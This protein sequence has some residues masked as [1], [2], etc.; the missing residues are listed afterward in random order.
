[1]NASVGLS[2]ALEQVRA[3]FAAEWEQPSR[4]SFQQC[5]SEVTAAEQ[6]QLL[7]ALV[8]VDWQERSKRGEQPH[9]EEYVEQFPEHRDALLASHHP[10]DDHSVLSTI[11][12]KS[13]KRS[14]AGSTTISKQ[15][16]R[17][18]LQKILGRGGFGIVWKALDPA[19]NRSVAIKI[20]RSDRAD[21]AQQVALLEEARKIAQLNHQGILKIHD[22][23]L[24]GDA[25]CI[26]S[27]WIGGGTLAEHREDFRNNPAAAA[28]LIA[29]AAD[30]LHYAHVCGIVHRDIKPQ[31]IL[32]DEHGRSRIADFGLAVTET[33]QLSEARGV[34]GTLAY[35][36]PEILKGD[37]QFAD[38]RSDVY[39]LGAV[40]YEML[41]GRRPFVAHNSDQWIEQALEREPRPPRSIDDRIPPELERICL[42][43]L[44]KKVTDRYTTAHDLAHDLR[45]AIHGK[46]DRQRQVAV[47]SVL[48]IAATLLIGFLL[49]KYVL[50][51]PAPQPGPVD[52][53]KAGSPSI[54]TG[55]E[56]PV[57]R[58]PLAAEFDEFP[59]PD[60]K[61]QIGL[62]KLPPTLFWPK[63]RDDSE[64]RH[65]ANDNSL[66]V[67]CPSVGLLH[68]GH[69]DGQK[70]GLQ[71]RISQ[72]GWQ[73]GVGF[74]FGYREDAERGPVLKRFQVVMVQQENSKG[75][76]QLVLSRHILGMDDGG[77]ILKQSRSAI[78]GPITFPERPAMLE[79]TVD[80]TSV[81]ARFNEVAALPPAQ[82]DV[83]QWIDAGKLRDLR[84]DEYQGKFGLFI[85]KASATFRNLNV[86]LTAMEKADSE[87]T[88]P[89]IIAPEEVSP[90]KAAP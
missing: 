4:P 70:L 55:P 86:K 33:E 88:A 51:G 45:H 8:E 36:S 66:H 63:N 37:C 2:P 77:R 62:S 41:A 54:D 17:Y 72:P 3:R 24:E 13:G 32:L 27:E 78:S 75:Q 29:Q 10:T 76:A 25:V 68:L 9:I 16:G 49:V 69:T 48:G 21:P 26:V 35:M 1:M 38:P 12:L 80:Q 73:G 43:C 42:K 82:Q 53:T 56:E 65:D 28:E 44:A 58:N 34:L 87:K 50:F 14:A 5:L 81:I 7:C 84:A 67:V 6:S 30:A 22:V 39:S 59:P 15:V 90:E 40:L 46:E 18:Q 71:V 11:S 47:A 20:L 31:N 85:D 52:V 57:S 61:W 64:R 74:F 83:P 60:D 89:E 23:L 79:L 19:L